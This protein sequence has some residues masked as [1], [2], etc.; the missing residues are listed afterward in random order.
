MYSKFGQPDAEM[1]S[2][3][4]IASSGCQVDVVLLVKVTEKIS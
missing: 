3:L 1:V 2:G 4:S